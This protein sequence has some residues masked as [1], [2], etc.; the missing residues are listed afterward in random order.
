MRINA[1]PPKHCPFTNPAR[2]IAY[3]SADPVDLFDD[4]EATPKEEAEEETL[5]QKKITPWEMMLQTDIDLTKGLVQQ[6]VCS[7]LRQSVEH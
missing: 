7:W 2:R 5:F 6:K 4:E 1:R 3:A